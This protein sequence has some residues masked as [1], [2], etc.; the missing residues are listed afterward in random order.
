MDKAQPEITDKIEVSRNF[1]TGER[2]LA[3]SNEIELSCCPSFANLM[4]LPL[5]RKMALLQGV[6]VILAMS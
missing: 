2:R 1:A 6:P 5:N 3:P 4:T